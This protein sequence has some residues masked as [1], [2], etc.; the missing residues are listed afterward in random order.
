MTKMMII[1]MEIQELNQSL[2]TNISISLAVIIQNAF[3][4]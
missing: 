2:M 4:Q 1:F 3:H